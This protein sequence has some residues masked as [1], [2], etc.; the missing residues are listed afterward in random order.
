MYIL[1]IIIA[2]FE[3]IVGIVALFNS[4]GQWLFIVVGISYILSGMLFG[5]LCSGAKQANENSD[6]I[7]GLENDIEHLISE[8]E[9]LRKA[10]QSPKDK[11]ESSVSPKSE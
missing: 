6:R 9:E 5:W 11:K 10:L 1:G 3:V 4:Q 8:N 2:I 7:R